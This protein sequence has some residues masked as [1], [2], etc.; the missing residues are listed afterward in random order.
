MTL[1]TPKTSKKPKA[2]K[3]NPSAEADALVDQRVG[4]ELERG[5]GQIRTRA[6]AEAVADRLEEDASGLT[7]TQAGHLASDDPTAAP[8]AIERA[9]G[10]AGAGGDARHQAADMLAQ[11]TAEA[12]A[13]T[14]EAP[15][16]VAAA[17]RSLDPSPD[18]PA[19]GAEESRR[20]AA[21]LRDTL[22]RRM[23][24]LHRL[25]ARTYLLVNGVHH[26][27]WLDR[28]AE[29][30]T[31]ITT[32]AWIWVAAGLGLAAARRELRWRTLLEL[33]PSVL[34]TTWL[35]EYPVK[36]L[37]CRERPFIDNVRA[38]VVGKQPGGWSF[39]S[40]HTAGSF[41]GA[42]ALSARWPRWSPAFFAL[43]SAVGFSRIYAGAHYPGDVLVGAAFGT[44]CS[45]AIRRGIRLGVEASK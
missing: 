42:T 38:L 6:D 32:G 22:L 1:K 21:L 30:V 11:A 13:D 26:P 15:G 18:A 4:D 27:A 20:G 24:P 39:P 37:F 8:A 29:R 28:L 16:V 10:A 9:A 5:L 35:A 7:E 2:P 3:P 23:R 31:L 36:A 34:F 43:A 12:V 19:A 44:V 25:D 33:S 17:Q 14:P 41:A 45:E 40:G